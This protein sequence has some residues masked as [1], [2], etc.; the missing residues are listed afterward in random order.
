MPL[1]QHAIV[2][3]AMTVGVGG[4]CEQAVAD[5]GEPARIARFG[6]AGRGRS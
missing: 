5:G 3:A 4:R 6:L 2:G 1:A